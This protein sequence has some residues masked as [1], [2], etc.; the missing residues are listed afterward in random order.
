MRLAVASLC[1]AIT[2]PLRGQDTAVVVDTNVA[3]PMRDGVVLRA[4]VWRPRSEGKYPVLVYRTPYGKHVPGPA[5]MT[6]RKAVRRGYVVVLQDVRGR[7]ASAGEFLPYQQEGNDGYDTIEWAA[8]QPWSN[9]A[10]GTFG[11]SYPGAVQ[12]LAAVQN[13][14]HL[15][16]M[17]PAMTFASPMQF[18][19]SN[20]I[21]DLSWLSWIWEN[22]APDRWRRLGQPAGLPW[23]SVKTEMLSALPLS[24]VPHL[25]YIAPWYYEWLRH[26][27]YDPWWDWADLTNKYASTSAAVLNFSAWY[28]DAYGPHGATTNYAGLVATRGDSAARTALILGPWPHGVPRS[29]RTSV[30]ERA[31]GPDG[32]IDYD[33]TVLRWMDHYVRGLDNGVEH[34]KA[35][36]FFVL[37]SNRWLTSDRWPVPGTQA[38]TLY[39]QPAGALARAQAER[40]DTAVI[41]S[42]PLHPVRDAYAGTPGAHDYRDLVNTPGTVTFETQPLDADLTV[43]GAIDAHVSV[44][45]DSRDTDL[46]IMVFDVAPDGTAFNLMSP[47][48]EALRLSHR[49]GKRDLLR[50]GRPYDVQLSDLFTGNTFLRGHRIRV[51]LL[52]SFFPDFSRNLN[53]GDPESRSLRTRTAHITVYVGGG[54]PSFLVLPVLPRSAML[55][56][57]Q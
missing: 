10:V 17:V 23:D 45:I 22:I 24:A 13:P 35:V 21:W 49:N 25:D 29:G 2:L 30:G 28:D 20:G 42:D 33:E 48:L 56:A 54:A 4:D 55:S 44:R 36:R 38:E 7:Y 5:Q 11:L 6:A 40:A 53:T 46:W 15:K 47:G 34:E 8:A 19:Y 18:W 39:F 14:P 31:Y 37:G 41:V 9:G 27:A 43:V 16:A 12:W 50:T 1:V 52:P 26:P 3:V 57:D 51:V 32:G